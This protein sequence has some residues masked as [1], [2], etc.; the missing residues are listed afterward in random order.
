MSDPNPEWRDTVPVHREGSN[1]EDEDDAPIEY[2]FVPCRKPKRRPGAVTDDYEDSAGN[3]D[4]PDATVELAIVGDSNVGKTSILRRFAKRAFTGD[5]NKTI[6]LEHINVWL[7]SNAPDYDRRTSVTLIDTQGH[8]KYCTVVPQL[9]RSPFGIFFVFDSTNEKSYLSIQRWR[10]TVAKYNSFARC[11]LVA[12]KMDLYKALPPEKRWMDVYDW[13]AVADA[14]QCD[15][16][17]FCVSAKDGDNIDSMIVEMVDMAIQNQQD[18]EAEYLAQD[19]QAATRRYT[20]SAGGVVNIN[21][22]YVSYSE[23]KNTNCKC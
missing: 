10:E 19:Q 1:S 5:R 18:I 4:D 16:G 15:G 7:F 6:G 11:M 17:F 9:L 21:N 13:G 3:E 2:K 12:N 20:A 8:D 14:L 23:S 22:R